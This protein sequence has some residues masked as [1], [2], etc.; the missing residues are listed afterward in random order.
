MY[1]KPHFTLGGYLRRAGLIC[2]WCRLWSQA[3]SAIISALTWTLCKRAIDLESFHSVLVR[4]P[5]ESWT[6][7]PAWSGASEPTLTLFHDS[8]S[9][10]THEAKSNREMKWMPRLVLD[11][12]SHLSLCFSLSSSQR[13]PQFR[14]ILKKHSTLWISFLWNVY[15]AFIPKMSSFVSFMYWDYEDDL[16]LKKWSLILKVE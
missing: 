6:R 7:V 5:N 11:G 10:S 14:M 8:R 1:L 15:K 3:P 9:F 4:R 12:H 2:F 13:Q 16:V